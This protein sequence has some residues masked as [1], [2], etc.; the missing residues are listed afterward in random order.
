MLYTVDKT[1]TSMISH[2]MSL[3][4][5]VDRIQILVIIHDISLYNMC[6]MIHDTN[7]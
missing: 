3:P 4:Y 7:S 6:N 1:K 2:D 5:T